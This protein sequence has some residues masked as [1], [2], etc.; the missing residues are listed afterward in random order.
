MKR[1]LDLIRE[2]LLTI[3]NPNVLEGS[4]L[5]LTECSSFTFSFGSDSRCEWLGT[6]SP[7]LPSPLPSHGIASP[8]GANMRGIIVPMGRFLTFA[9]RARSHGVTG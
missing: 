1:S 5:N 7:P 8:T 9:A 2:I 3:E 6:L 4:R